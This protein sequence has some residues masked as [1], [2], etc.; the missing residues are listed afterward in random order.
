[1]DRMAAAGGLGDLPQP[2]LPPQVQ[3]P[4]DH[5]SFGTFFRCRVMVALAMAEAAASAVLSIRSYQWSAEHLW[6]DDVPGCSP[7]RSIIDISAVAVLRALL[8]LLL[9]SHS[10]RQLRRVTSILAIFCALSCIFSLVKFVSITHAPNGLPCTT[11]PDADKLPRDS[12]FA[13]SVIVLS[14]SASV[15]VRFC[16]I[17]S[18]ECAGFTQQYC[19]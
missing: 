2:L 11:D 17:V 13:L 1:M 10:A 14:L 4:A 18:I 15:L 7:L 5:L 3:A 12:S 19:D 16:V 9:L 6:T 8:F